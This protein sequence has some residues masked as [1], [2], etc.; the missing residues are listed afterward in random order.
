MMQKGSDIMQENGSSLLELK[1]REGL[2]VSGVQNVDVF[3]EEK[4]ILRTEQGMLEI[5]GAELNIT[6]LDLETGS[7]QIAGV[8]DTVT[9]PKEKQKRQA[10]NRPKESFFHKM[11]S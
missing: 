11:L 7:L 4:I 3:E 1:N 10:R 2:S 6:H 5:Q 8:I 9:Y